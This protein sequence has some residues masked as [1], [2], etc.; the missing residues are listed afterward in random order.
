[1]ALGALG[2]LRARQLFKLLQCGQRFVLV[3]TAHLW[4]RLQTT[5]AG[6]SLRLAEN[7]ATKMGIELYAGYSRCFAPW[8]ARDGAADRGG[9][10]T[11][12]TTRSA[13]HPSVIHRAGRY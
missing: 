4:R 3:H 10:T 6:R 12:A 11:G 8:R 7:L 9:D 1:M 5:A 13:I 2:Y